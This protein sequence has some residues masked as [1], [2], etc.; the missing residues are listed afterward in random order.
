[1]QVQ[2]TPAPDSTRPVRYEL[3]LPFE[4]RAAVAERPVAY[5]PLGAC[6]WHAEHLPVGLEALAAHGICLR[7]AEQGGGVVLPALHYGTGGDHA[8]YPWSVI[9]EG[10]R[11]IKTLLRRTLS[12]LQDF[13]FALAVLFSGHSAP[14]QTA[15]IRRL[16]RE[17]AAAGNRMTVAALG[18]DMIEGLPLAP[19]HAAIFETT[20]FSELWP[21]RVRIDRLPDLADSPSPEPD[22][23]SWARHAPGHPLYGVIGPDPRT[24]DPAHAPKLLD[25]AVGWLVGQAR[26]RLNDL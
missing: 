1:M 6:E 3:M 19:D 10:S 18:I 9:M 24:F 17:W 8:L 2:A 11:E 4:L 5:L 7:A 22:S 25:A 26:A 12:R 13:G 16:T 23:R 21:D 14:Q 20:L 15:M